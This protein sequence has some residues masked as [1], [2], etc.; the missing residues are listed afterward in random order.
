[1]SLQ[2]ICVVDHD[3]VEPWVCRKNIPF[4]IWSKDWLGNMKRRSIVEAPSQTKPPNSEIPAWFWRGELI[5]EVWD[6]LEKRAVKKKSRSNVRDSLTHFFD[7]LQA[8]ATHG[9]KWSL[10]HVTTPWS[11]CATCRPQTRWS[12]AWKKNMIWSVVIVQ[13]LVKLEICR[14]HHPSDYCSDKLLSIQV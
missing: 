14:A 7:S 11:L 9:L 12:R 13:L 8:H 10:L 1:M 2:P 6:V 4:T 5:F 3:T